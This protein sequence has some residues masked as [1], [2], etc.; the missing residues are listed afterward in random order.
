[1]N[2][3]VTALGLMSGTSLDGVDAAIIETDG[4][5]V[6]AYGPALTQAYPDDL[7]AR[8]RAQLGVREIDPNLSRALTDFHTDIVDQLLKQN[9][10]INSNIT[11]IGF[12]GQTVDHHPDQGVTVQIGDGARLAAGTGIDVVNQFRLADVAAGGEG[13]PLAPLYHA[14]LAEPLAKPVAVLNLGGVGNVTWIGSANEED[15]LAFDTGPAN[16][17]IDDWIHAQ[18]GRTFDEGGEIAASGRIDDARVGRAMGHDFFSRKPPKSLDR[19]DFKETAEA[20]VQG[21][22]LAD[23]AANLTAF[24]VEAVV[25]AQRHFPAP[26][27]RWLVTGGGRHNRF[28]MNSLAAKLAAAPAPVES[29]GWRGD[30]LEAEAFA[31]LAVRSLAGLALSLPGTTGVGAPTAGGHLHRA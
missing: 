23:G 9:S 20:L 4:Q 19:N 3:P 8:L 25:A 17:P 7:R 30:F 5:R 18:G 11:I 27:R 2:K 21:C 10:L 12:H 29:V 22:S 24:T 13:A 26:P 1:M 15:I 16:A 14:A 31:F 28:L 6:S